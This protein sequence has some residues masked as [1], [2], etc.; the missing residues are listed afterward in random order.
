[1]N[2][3]EDHNIV[4]PNYDELRPGLKTESFAYILGDDH[5]SL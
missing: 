2:C 3:L 5:L 1:M 4:F